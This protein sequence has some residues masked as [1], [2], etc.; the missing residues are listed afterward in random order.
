M[1]VRIGIVENELLIAENIYVVLEEL[2]YEPLEPVISY[3]D[4]IEMIENKMPDLLLLDIQLSGKK[5]GIELAET[6]RS[7][8]QIPFIFLTANADIA[9]LARAKKTLPPAY[10]VKPFSKEDLFSAIEICLF[11]FDGANA[12]ANTEPNQISGN[13]DHI[14]IKV[15]QV[16]QK[17]SF[18]E[19]VMVESD[20]NYINVVTDTGKFAVRATLQSFLDV[21]PPQLFERVHKCNIINVARITMIQQ[22]KVMLGKFEVPL[23]KR[24]KDTFLRNINVI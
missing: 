2:G 14:F 7:K 9:T 21:V 18:A 19:I 4:A 3:T 1:K 20:N 12:D 8:Y 22:D 11:N 16:L 13:Q 17:I 23:S 10:I 24:Y 6:V 15:D 5:D